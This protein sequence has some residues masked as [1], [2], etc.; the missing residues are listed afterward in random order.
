MLCF[1][2]DCVRPVYSVL[3]VSLDCPIL[4]AT[5]V[6]FNIYLIINA[7]YLGTVNFNDKNI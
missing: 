3:P 5:S 4:I 7:H 2:F 1:C 6:F